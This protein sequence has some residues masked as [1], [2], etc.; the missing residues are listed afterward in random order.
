[1]GDKHV[2]GVSKA[3]AAGQ[4][5]VG[6]FLFAGLIPGE[7]EAIDGWLFMPLGSKGA[8]PCTAVRCVLPWCVALAITTRHWTPSRETN[9]GFVKEGDT[10]IS[11]RF[12]MCRIEQICLYQVY[13]FYFYQKHSERLTSLNTP[14]ESGLLLPGVLPL[15]CYCSGGTHVVTQTVDNVQSAPVRD[16]YSH[17]D[18]AEEK[19]CHQ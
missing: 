17:S 5:T 1:M 8:A 11:E 18:E 14:Q 2:I 13:S 4:G 12:V 9:K 19:D 3:I 15:Y 10:F 16:A 6:Q 7:G